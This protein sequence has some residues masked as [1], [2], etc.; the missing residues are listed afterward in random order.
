MLEEKRQTVH[1]NKWIG[2]FAIV[3]GQEL[4]ATVDFNIQT[5]CISGVFYTEVDLSSEAH[6]VFISELLVQKLVDIYVLV[7]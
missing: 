2:G 5:T 6:V 1:F 4:T 3:H 7:K